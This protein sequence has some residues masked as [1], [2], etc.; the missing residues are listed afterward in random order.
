M[1]LYTAKVKWYCEG[2]E[3][4]LTDYLVL[5][6]DGMADAASQLI[7]RYGE[8]NIDDIDIKLINYDH[9]FVRLPDKETYDDITERGEL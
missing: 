5:A 4:P 1:Q 8:A 9:P 3:I 2:E 7:G 6:A